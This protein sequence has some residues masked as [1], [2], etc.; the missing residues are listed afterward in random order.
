MKAIHGGKS[1]NDEVDSR[2]TAALLKGGLLSMSYL[3]PTA[4]R[5]TRDLF[6]RRT[7]VVRRRG[8]E[9]LA[10]IIKGAENP[11][12]TRKVCQLKGRAWHVSGGG[13]AWTSARM[14]SA[15]V[16]T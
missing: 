16:C 4:M 15:A 14:A 6:R 7:Y 5:A 13:Q 10:S 3:Y 2:K 1:K 9:R 8:Q 11:G 12:R